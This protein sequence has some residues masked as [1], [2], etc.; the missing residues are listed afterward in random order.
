M[1]RPVPPPSAAGVWAVTV[2]QV[3]PAR[4]SNYGASLLNP[5]IVRAHDRQ[6]TQTIAHPPHRQVQR[7]RQPRKLQMPRVDQDIAINPRDHAR[8]QQDERALLNL[9]RDKSRRLC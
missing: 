8:R 7:M 6:L 1:K 5:R 3:W 4:L 9:T 2:P